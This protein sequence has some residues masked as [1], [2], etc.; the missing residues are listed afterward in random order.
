MKNLLLNFFL[1]LSISLLTI[2]CTT[3]Q[4]SPNS[5]AFIT[6]LGND[7]LAVESFVIE[8]DMV[9]ATVIL[10]TPRTA[11]TT[12]ELTLNDA[13]GVSSMLTE[14]YGAH[15]PDDS[16]A[17][18][19]SG[20]STE[21]DSLKIVFTRRGELQE[22]MAAAGPSTLPF[23][24]MVHWPYEL[25]LRK[26]KK[27]GLSSLDQSLLA[28]S[29][30][31]PFEFRIFGADSFSIQHPSRGTMYGRVGENGELLSLDAG[32]TTRKLT[33]ERVDAVDVNALL[34]HF[35]AMDE[36]GKGVGPLSG[37]A[38]TT[39]EVDGANFTVTHGQPS[40]RGRELFGGIVPWNQRWR[41]GANRATHFST[42]KDLMVRDLEV[43]AGEYTLFTIPAPDGGTLIINKQTGQNGRSYDE[44]QDLGRVP[45]NISTSDE[46]V[47]EF[48][49]EVVD[50]EEGGVIQLKW[51]KTIFE[52]PFTV[53]E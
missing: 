17:A 52:I 8:E 32:Q 53:K 34:A 13:G 16:E 2:Q 23:I 15:S 36:G 31:R 11:L 12:Y 38:E 44:S 29:R 26:M 10:R 39:A 30:A 6:R 51:G 33:V 50:T 42:D 18:S 20:I 28:G 21:G 27:E 1:I 7:T 22:R 14:D 45:M 19:Q 48:T 49:I 41:T 5:G 35:A 9:E 47:E 25:V 46:E 4:Q 37:A 40:K 3:D 43:P 24:D